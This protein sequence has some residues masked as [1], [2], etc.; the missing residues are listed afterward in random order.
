MTKLKIIKSSN[1][2]EIKESLK[3][4]DGN[5]PC[6]PRYVWNEDTKCICKEFREQQTIGNCHCLAF[7]KILVEE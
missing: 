3:N 4:T 5:C 1:Y 7:Q 2:D 6:L